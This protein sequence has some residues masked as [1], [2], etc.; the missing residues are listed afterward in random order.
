MVSTTILHITSAKY[1]RFFNFA[2]VYDFTLYSD[3]C[4]SN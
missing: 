2:A 4:Y 3:R 1:W